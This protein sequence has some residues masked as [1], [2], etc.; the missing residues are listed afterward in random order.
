[1]NKNIVLATYNDIDYALIRL[2]DND[3]TPFCAAWG[4]NPETETWCQGHYFRTLDDAIDYIRCKRFGTE[5]VLAETSRY[6]ITYDKGNDSPFCVEK[7]CSFYD[8]GEV[9]FVTL[10]DAMR[11]ARNETLPYDRMAEIACTAIS[12]LD[13][14]G[15]L[16]DYL[17]DR[18]ID[19]SRDEKDYFVVLDPDDDEYYEEDDE[20]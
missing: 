14:N 18:D 16:S 17:E 19:L 20:D 4:Y 13:D 10:E 7:K 1:M 15:S 11:Y 12:Y 6:K 8:P 5:T 2:W 3:L 9:S